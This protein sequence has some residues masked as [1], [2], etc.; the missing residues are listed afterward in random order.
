MPATSLVIA[1]RWCSAAGVPWSN[2]RQRPGRIGDWPSGMLFSAARGLVANGAGTPVHPPRRSRSPAGFAQ[3]RNRSHKRDLT[4]WLGAVHGPAAT[5]ACSARR[6]GFSRP[7]P[8]ALPQAPACGAREGQHGILRR[9]FLAT[10]RPD[11]EWH[12]DCLYDAVRPVPRVD[13]ELLSP[14]M[15]AQ[16]IRS[17]LSHWSVNGGHALKKMS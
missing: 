12:I 14:P 9:F 2:V 7:A 15:K 4:V 10:K 6:S 3:M 11:G 17:R 1:A 5:G 8:V 13:A 16:P